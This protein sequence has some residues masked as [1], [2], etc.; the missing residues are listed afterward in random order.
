MS[1]RR[2][3]LVLGATL[4]IGWVFWLYRIGVNDHDDMLSNE[5]LFARQGL[6]TLLFRNPWPD[7]SPLYFL[8]LHALRTIGESPF[9]IQ[10]ANAALLTATL[11]ATY[12][13]A[14]AFFPSRAVAR[15]AVFIGAVSPTSLWLVRN[16]RM[17]SLQVLFAVLAAIFVLRYLERRRASDLVAFC[18]ASVLNIYTHFFGFLITAL[19]FVPAMA[20][21]WLRPPDPDAAPLL[22][23]WRR[24][25]AVAWAAGA[26]ALLSVPQIVRLASLVT[27]DVPSARADVSLPGL[28]PR[29][30]DRVSWF[31][32]VNADW[33]PLRPGEQLITA[34]YVGSIVL[35]AAAGLAAAGRRLAATAAL[36]ILVPLAAVGLAAGR[37]DVRDRYFV[38][39]LPL[40][41]VAVA[42]GGF[43]A[44]PSARVTG[45]LA[46]IAR[47]V[48]AALV[49]AVATASLWL[50]WHKLPERYAEWTKLMS[51]IERVYRPSMNVYMPPGSPM[52][53]PR[54]IAI[55]RRLPSGLQDVRE[56]S[57]TTHAQ[58]LQEVERGQ[59]FVFLVYNGLENDEMRAR[60]RYLEA[61]QYLAA[62]I[63]V[64]G[65]SARIF[66]RAAVAGWSET[67]QLAGTVSPAAIAAWAREQRG[68]RA[69]STPGAPALGGAFV[70][71]VAANGAART[72]SLFVSQRGEYGAWRLG[73]EPWDAVEEQRVTSGRIEHTAI[74]A[75]P[76]SDS[77]LVVALPPQTMS[78]SLDLAYGIAD[79]GLGFRGGASVELSVYVNGEWKAD[80]S[81]PNTPG[82][83]HLSIDT[84]SLD[85]QTADAV[86]VLTTVDDRSRHFAFRLDASPR[87][88]AS[89]ASAVRDPS[90]FVLTG[91]RRLSD[92]VERLR[93]YRLDAR[94][95]VDGVSDGRTYAAADMHE[96]S[97][98]GGEGAVHRVWALGPLLWD[99]V[100]STRQPSGGEVRKGIWAH[101]RDGTTLVIEADQVQLGDLLRGQFGISDVG[102]NMAQSTGVT[103]PITFTIAID[104]QPVFHQE[105][106]RAAGWL[107]LAVPAGRSAGA[108]TLRIE[109]ASASDKWGHFVFDL[110]SD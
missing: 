5:L 34:I 33:G 78:K 79:S 60:V 109:I 101:P 50:L 6:A 83:K 66:S 20:D 24:L 42:A 9:V 92:T 103:A 94:G 108:H 71:R 61:R 62:T 26:V 63:P 30:F 85:R 40:L 73:P 59:E 86:L 37:I 22:S 17:Y 23:R 65:A 44:L 52:G 89:A 14:I 35:L 47:G 53:I 19:L 55:Q 32:F 107:G 2:D 43:G 48:R 72:G 68:E 4:V 74:A 106:A 13:L 7:Q 77:A 81:C 93:V 69:V 102:V 10:V 96:A 29:F 90:P 8:Y 11:T 80:L 49:V 3:A 58:F 84:A 67:R 45:A 104:G 54:L 39:T 87:P 12:F 16:G 97:G 18:A 57:A 75:H 25:R 100:G 38:W 105:V 1:R 51:G 36:W 95:R 88:A 21:A 56:L 46:D 76:A 70:A 99:A 41:W 28:S 98:A 82:W 110:W 64:Y 15:A 27:G 31:W 91:G